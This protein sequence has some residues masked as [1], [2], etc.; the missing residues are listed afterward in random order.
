MSDTEHV[1]LPDNGIQTTNGRRPFHS[2][3]RRAVRRLRK[4]FVDWR[5]RYLGYDYISVLDDVHLRVYAD[6][7]LGHLLRYGDF[8]V[9][10]Q[11]FLKRILRPGDVFV[12]AGAN[13]GLYSLLAG[14]LV[15]PSGSV[16]A[17]EPC[18]ATFERLRENVRRS[19]MPQISCH[20]IAL[21]NIA[22]PA[23]LSVSR[24]GFD[25]WNSLAGILADGEFTSESVMTITWDAFWA[26]QTLQKRVTVMKIDVEGWEVPV[27]EGAYA[28]LSRADAPVLQVEF[29]P[30]NAAT[31]G[32]SSDQLFDRIRQYGYTLYRYDAADETLCEVATAPTQHHCNLYGIKR[33]AELMPRLERMVPR[34]AIHLT[35]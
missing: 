30:A 17:F 21:S 27:L 26:Q 12:D 33:M 13:I 5:W 14:R 22:G 20:R 35:K 15:G 19:G 16:L 29:T 8:E 31:A 25:A 1:D 28:L 32:S 4:I 2:L 3:P 10:E 6:G 34:R 7:R 24:S 18:A 23:T 9:S 11:A